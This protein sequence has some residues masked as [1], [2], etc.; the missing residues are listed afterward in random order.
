MK[1]IKVTCWGSRGSCPAPYES[2]MEYGGNTTCFIIESDSFLLI[3][4]GGTGIAA[5]GESLLKRGDEILGKEIHIFISHLHLDHIAGI[6]FFKPGY[7]EGYQIHF[8]GEGYKRHSLKEQLELIFGPPYWPVGLNQWRAR[9][10]YTP[11]KAGESMTLSCGIQ[12]DTLRANHPDQ[13][14]LYRFLI[15][16]KRIVY[17]LD[18]ELDELMMKHMECFADHA[19]LL[20]CDAQY[21]PKEYSAHKGWGHSTWREGAKLAELCHV[22]HVWFSHF[23]WESEDEDLNRLEREAKMACAVG[24]YAREGLE[25]F[26]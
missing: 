23:S 22:K 12:V 18:C 13:T 1:N 11:V 2:R 5:L 16:G 24:V 17:A 14:V 9:V 15:G 6:P 4:D 10:E 19:D 25:I 21:D 26:L 20:I 7:Q 8:Y 3:L